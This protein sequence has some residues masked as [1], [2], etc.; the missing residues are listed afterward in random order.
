MEQDYQAHLDYAN[1][2]TFFMIHNHI[3]LTLVEKD[4][5]VATLTIGPD[6]LNPMGGLHG[7]AYF[8]MAD[9]V[10]GAAARSAGFLYVTQSS[11]INFVRGISSGEIMAEAR[12]RYRGRR[13][14]L[15]VVE[16][17][18]ERG[19]LLAEVSLTMF[20]LGEFQPE[21]PPEPGR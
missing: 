1:A 12:V 18:D 17:T 9:C 11:N 5:A 20:C 13:T 2:R 6:S 10:A 3:H 7:G 16:L 19:R 14:C 4:R 15:V 8:T 21:L